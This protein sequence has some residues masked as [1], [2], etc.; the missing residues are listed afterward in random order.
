LISI[1]WSINGIHNIVDLPNGT[2]Y[3]RALFTDVVIP[4]LIES[5]RSQTRRETLKSWLTHIAN[6]RPHNSRRARKCIEVP[7]TERLPCLA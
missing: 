1:I 7:R 6:A 4:S 5:V 3:H 2:T